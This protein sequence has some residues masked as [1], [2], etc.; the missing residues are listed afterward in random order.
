[1]MGN[2]RAIELSVE[3]D[4]VP[5]PLPKTPCKASPMVR[6]VFLLLVV[7]IFP[8]SANAADVEHVVLVSVDG[9]SASYLT[10]P[11]ELMPNLK[12]IAEQAQ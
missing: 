7:V 8:A 9:L 3:Y 11:R 10:G 1:M 4:D 12:A 6:S 5:A 2:K